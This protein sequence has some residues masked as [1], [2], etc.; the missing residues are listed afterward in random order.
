MGGALRRRPGRA[1]ILFL[2]VE[3][4]LAQGANL[5]TPSATPTVVL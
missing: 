4:D 5:K 3:A 2:L 1:K